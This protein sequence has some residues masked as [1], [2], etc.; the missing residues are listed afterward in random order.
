MI[1]KYISAWL[2]MMVLAIL[3]GTARDFFYGPMMNNQAAHQLSTI[4]LILL[5][6]GWFWYLSNRHPLE[7]SKQAWGIGTIWLVMTL[8]FETGM[9]LFLSGQSWSEIIQQYNI[10]SGNLWVLIP[11]WIFVGPYVFF[12]IHQK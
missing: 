10:L 7:S 5:F 2:G 11:L 9:G 4:L 8:A 12:R 1:I 6:A 3:N